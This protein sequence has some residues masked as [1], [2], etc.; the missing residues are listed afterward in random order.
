MI[1]LNAQ[2]HV[3]ADAPADLATTTLTYGTAFPGSLDAVTQG[4]GSTARTYTLHYDPQRRPD[5][6]T[7]PLA[8]QALLAYDAADRVT[9]LTIPGGRVV[10][11]T[12]D[13]TGN[14]T[15]VTPPGQPAHAFGYTPVDLKSAY[16]P[17]VVPGTGA[18]TYIYNGD[19][20]LELVTRPNGQTIDPAYDA[21][22]GRV[23]T[24]TVPDGVYTYSYYPAGAL[25]PAAPGALSSITMT[26]P[27]T[28]ALAFACDGALPTTTTWSGPVEGSVSRTYDN[29]FRVAST[30]VNGANAVS[31]TYDAD[32]P[33]TQAGALT[34]ERNGPQGLVSKL[35]VGQVEEMR[36]YTSFGELATAT[37]TFNGAALL[38]LTYPTRDALGR[39]T[40]QTKSVSGAPT[41]T[42]AYGYDAAGRLQDVTRDGVPV[43]P[44][45][46]YTYDGN[47]N[48]LTAPGLSGT[49]VYDAQDRLRVYGAATYDYTANGALLQKTVGSA[50]TEYTYDILGNL[51]AVTLPNGTLIEYVI[52]AMRRRVGKRVN[53]TLVQAWLYDGQLRPIAELDAS[54]AV[55]SRFVYGTGTNIPDYMTKNGATYRIIADHIGS[56]N[57]VVDATTGTIAQRMEYDEFGNVIVDTQPGFQPFGFAGGLYDADTGFVHFGA[58][59]Y[60]PKIG[61]WTAKDPIRFDGGDPNLYGYALQDPINFSDPDGLDMTDCVVAV[62]RCGK[63]VEAGRECQKRHS[64]PVACQDRG[65]NPGPSVTAHI[66]QECFQKNPACSDDCGP[67]LL[68]CTRIKP[69]K[70]TSEW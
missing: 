4:S 70:V 54:G 62:A 42:L 49:P 19:R 30:S 21:T 12:Y 13:A 56:P 10:G 28:S 60:E 5:I 32:S 52:D 67:A 6:V 7:D 36:T 1:T 45:P 17:P 2:G 44:S 43:A 20:Q 57:L 68:N 11:V 58:R 65:E 26:V 64:D 31:A 14:V 63:C 48:R 34:L 25:P 37:A 16:T 24:L 55:A 3:I 40:T 22:T 53:G 39:I 35:T 33:L 51:R 66:M 47:G 9:T 46:A 41:S 23:A 27:L 69:P 18:T 8:R 38:S 59:D 29:D 61:R 50:V 15:S